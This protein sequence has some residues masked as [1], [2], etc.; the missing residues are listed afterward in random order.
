MNNPKISVL[1]LSY[2]HA[3]YIARAVRSALWSGHQAGLTEVILFDDGSTDDTPTV[4]AELARQEP[5]LRY[6]ILDHGGVESIA[7][8]FN[9]LVDSA[10]G[11]YITFLSADDEILSRRFNRPVEILEANHDISGV[12]SNGVNVLNGK[13]LGPVVCGNTISL[14][15]SGDPRDIYTHITNNFS[16]LFI[17][18]LLV[19]R[20]FFDG[21]VGFDETLIADDWVFNIRFFSRAHAMAKKVVFL[22]ETAFARHLL[23]SRT[24]ANIEVHS[25]RVEQVISKYVEPSSRQLLRRLFYWKLFRQSLKARHLKSVAR[26]SYSI[27]RSF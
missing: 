5:M 19:R 21:F 20:E 16:D 4:L 8:N 26:T 23:P 22:D 12:Y 27:L 1:V 18:G 9:H 17:Q 7:K 3:P 10:T 2:N 11:D 14:F 13:V 15:A 24:S 6:R 25:K